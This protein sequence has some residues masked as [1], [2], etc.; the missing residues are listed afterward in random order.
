M[1]EARTNMPVGKYPR[2]KSPRTSGKGPKNPEA[3]SA[4]KEKWKDPEFRERMRNR[5][6]PTWGRI[7]GV[8]DGMRHPEASQLWALARKKAS[9]VMSELEKEGIVHFDPNVTDDQMARKAL[10]E[11][12]AMVVSPLGDSK[13]RHSAMRTVLEW[14]KAKPATKTQLN[15][16]SA[17][18]WLKEVVNDHRASSDQSE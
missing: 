4:L 8:P 1:I 14:T 6:R 12:F 11:A 9:Y 16:N 7:G 15:I 5:P 13:L 2:K 18:E 10:E 17:E 3:S